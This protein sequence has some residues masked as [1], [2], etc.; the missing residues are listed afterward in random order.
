MTIR[1]LPPDVA[2]KIA[3][4]EVVE[5]PASVVKEL[6]ENA[7]DAGARTIR[8][9][10]QG[11]GK[12]LIRVMDDGGGIAAEEV[13]LAF[14]RHATS[15]LAS[16]EDLSRV[17]TLGFRGE[18]LASIAA[19]SQLTL[20]SRPAAQPAATRIRLEG[21][22]QLA[23][24]AAGSPGGTIIT[25]ENLFYNV[26]ARLKFLKADATEAAHIHRIVSHYALAY[27]Q[28][29][30]ALQSDNRLTFQTNGSG[31][32]F[33]TLAAVFDLETARQMILVEYSEPE[34]TGGEEAK[35]G[36]DEQNRNEPHFLASSLHVS[37]PPLSVHGYAGAPA[38]H[39]GARDQL[40][41][42]VN[43]RWIQDR[44]L[45][46]AVV[47]AYHTFLPVGRFPVAVLN[48]EID[49]AEV[50]VNVHP[51]KAEVKF[52]DPREIFKAVQKGVRAAVTAAAPVPAYGGHS[53]LTYSFAG[54]FGGH[55]GDTAPWHTAFGGHSG[56]GFSQFGFEAQ[57]TL[58]LPGAAGSEGER[59]F[60]ESS[61]SQAMPLMRVVGQ[62][63]Q[64]YIVAEGPD[65]LYLIDQHAAHERVLYEKLTAQKAQA[66]VARQQMLEPVVVEL[67]PGH[68]ALLEAEWDALTEVG[69]E[70]EPFGGTTYRLRAVPEMLS[71][72]DPARALVD[73]LAE[74]ADGAIPLARETHEK[75]AITVCKRAS[76]K[77]GQ[78]L[79]P[80]EMRELVRQLEATSAPR[81]CPH[82]RPTMIHMSAAQLAR[83]FG[84]V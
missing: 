65:G 76:I 59:Q 25:V 26:P 18:A 44:S 49:P 11:G 13:P 69:F 81:T 71:R 38:L 35:R 42:F 31:E 17:M 21:G 16:V 30:F 39:R 24:G 8:V 73:I 7:I 58:P 77:G 6:V 29:R 4:G 10:I 33:D 9:E 53:P 72:A 62:I 36:R 27:P 20:V 66:A 67:S 70:L 37:S 52:R 19:V 46:Q 84:R 56:S 61:P 23:L 75:I 2:A 22:Q 3:A 14:A 40:I 60:L 78:I 5:R 64:M 12:R 1:I 79:S 15:K 50:D 55:A 74:M 80:E 57:R 48:I 43:R 83:E 51:T 28:I 68:A 45:N 41:F 63:Q 47:Q 32:L 54:D 82:G 34:R